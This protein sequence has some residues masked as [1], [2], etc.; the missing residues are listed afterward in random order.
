V[1]TPI[2][3]DRSPPTLRRAPEYGGDTDAI[4]ESLGRNSEAIIQA[5]VGGA[6]I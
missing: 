2:Q 1:A 3:F 6:V 5:R 4:L